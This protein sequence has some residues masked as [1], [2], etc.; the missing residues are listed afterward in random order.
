[1]LK[2]EIINKIKQQKNFTIIWD[3]INS[4]Y[5]KCSE[6]MKK[7]SFIASEIIYLIGVEN[8]KSNSNNSFN[9]IVDFIR[10]IPHIFDVEKEMTIEEI[11]DISTSLMIEF[12]KYQNE[13]TEKNKN[14][15][16]S[17]MD[18]EIDLLDSFSLLYKLSNK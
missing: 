4:G 13:F 17:L 16:F 18:L 11:Y 7:N 2:L 8:N 9:L 10:T 5:K 14:K 3:E 1:M 12:E 6:L 15:Y